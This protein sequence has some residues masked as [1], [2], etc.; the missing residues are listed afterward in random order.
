[1]LK[2]YVLT[3][4]QQTVQSTSS[5]TKQSRR[6]GKTSVYIIGPIRQRNGYQLQWIFLLQQF[7]LTH[8]LRTELLYA[9]QIV[10]TYNL[11]TIKLAETATATA[12]R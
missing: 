12:F 6:K 5:E 1:M 7:F 11:L 2:R 8:F 9:A 4:F 10:S 3:P